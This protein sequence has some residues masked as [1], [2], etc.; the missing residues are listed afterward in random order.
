V[1]SI[2]FKDIVLNN[3]KGYGNKFWR[4][5]FDLSYNNCIKILRALHFWLR[6]MREY[7][8]RVL[9]QRENKI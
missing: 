8:T 1:K 9:G 7:I 5:A 3:C 6:G 4:V 2:N